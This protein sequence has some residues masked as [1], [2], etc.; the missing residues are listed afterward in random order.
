MSRPR[1]SREEMLEGGE[2]RE[3][4]VYYGI[5][6]S[7]RATSWEYRDSSSLT[8]AQVMEQ[9]VYYNMAEDVLLKSMHLLN[10]ITA[11][12]LAYESFKA[13]IGRWQSLGGR[14]GAAAAISGA[15][16]KMEKL[17]EKI[18]RLLFLLSWFRS[19]GEMALL[20]AEDITVYVR[21]RNRFQPPRN[22][23]L[24]EISRRDCYTWFGHLPDDLRQLYIHWRIPESF[25]IERSRNT[26]TGEE[27][28]LIFMYHMIQG[29]HSRRWRRIF[30]GEIRGTCQ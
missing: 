26:F 24:N 25:T 15:R 4:E 3:E 12:F 21:R 1:R 28:F 29:T 13:R 30:L 18:D 17:K 9:E 6:R 27:C 2:D 19:Y 11:I 23:T 10:I 20:Y 16:E 14:V 8:P 5:R 7:R 22:R